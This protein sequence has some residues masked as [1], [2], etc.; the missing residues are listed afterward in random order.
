MYNDKWT[1]QSEQKR[2]EKKNV[3]G[4][5]SNWD[6]WTV[7]E[8]IETSRQYVTTQS[9]PRNHNFHTNVLYSFMFS[10]EFTLVQVSNNKR[11]IKLNTK[12]ETETET[13]SGL[14]IQQIFKINIAWEKMRHFTNA[15]GKMLIEKMS[16]KMNVY[17]NTEV[18]LSVW[19]TDVNDSIDIFYRNQTHKNTFTSF[20]WKCNVASAE[21][22]KISWKKRYYTQ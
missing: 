3:V 9:L 14:K 7:H 10:C 20:W 17:R 12:E 5:K 15:R 21:Q 1:H 19:N 13:F 18:F 4:N 6:E 8:S 11:N 2:N 16:F 22:G